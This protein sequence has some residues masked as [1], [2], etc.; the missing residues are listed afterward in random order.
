MLEGTD[1]C[2]PPLCTIHLMQ[3]RVTCSKQQWHKDLVQPAY[4]CCAAWAGQ[5]TGWPVCVCRKES[6]WREGGREFS[7]DH[8]LGRGLLSPAAA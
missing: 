4:V 1:A 8:L 3:D 5:L 6:K 2:V 7:P